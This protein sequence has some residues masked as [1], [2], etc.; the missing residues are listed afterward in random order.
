[1]CP[2]MGATASAKVCNARSSRA[3][4]VSLKSSFGAGRQGESVVCKVLAR[5][6]SRRTGCRCGVGDCPS[7]TWR[8][9]C[10]APSER[11]LPRPVVARVTSRSCR[12]AKPR[13]ACTTRSIS[14][15]APTVIPSRIRVAVNT[16]SAA[17]RRARCH[18]IRVTWPSRTTV[19][20]AFIVATIA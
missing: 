20:G 17:L 7:A 5:S 6:P 9:N 10:S 3:D 13:S 2:A 14:T 8:V 18:L 19:V 4:A 11:T 1:M 16:W 15:L 12:T